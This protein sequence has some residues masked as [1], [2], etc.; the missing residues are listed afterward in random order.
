MIKLNRIA[1]CAA[2]GVSAFCIGFAGVAVA[3]AAAETFFGSLT[4]AEVPE[5]KT[6]EFEP[7]PLE[8]ALPALEPASNEEIEEDTSNEFYAHGSFYIDQENLPREFRDFEH[9][10]IQTHDMAQLRE[11]DTYGVRIPP[12]GWVSA[13][14]QFAFSR[15]AINAKDISFQTETVDGVSYR[16]VG[17]YHHVDYC[18]TDGSTPDLIGRLIKI[19][20]GKWA[21]EMKAE[22]YA[23]C[24]C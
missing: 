6:T 21:A 20:D 4:V 7:I 14:V 17:Q 24:G 16:F 2:A 3:T 1:L 12:K 13:K 19:K 10:E 9:I 22:L 5:V 18:E 23:Q 8:P 11:D 15:I